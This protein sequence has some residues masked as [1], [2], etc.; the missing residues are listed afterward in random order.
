MFE[1]TR[2]IGQQQADFARTLMDE[3]KIEISGPIDYRHSYVYMPT[4]N[5]TLADGSVKSLCTASMGYA[6][7][8]GTTD[9]TGM[10]NFTQGETTGNP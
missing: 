10:F 9:G 2:I 3:A 5:V 8:A 4:L 1:S 7:A 6:F